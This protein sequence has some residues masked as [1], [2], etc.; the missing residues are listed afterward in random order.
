MKTFKAEPNLT[1]RFNPPI[2]LIKHVQ[3]DE[4]GEY[5]TDNERIIQRFMSKFDSVPVKDETPR[6]A[7]QEQEKPK[8]VTRKRGGK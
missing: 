7:K 3:F 8:K 4:K 2:G 6:E 5:T 1:V